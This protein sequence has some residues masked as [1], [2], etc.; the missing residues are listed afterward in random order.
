MCLLLP[1]LVKSLHAHKNDKALGV[2]FLKVVKRVKEAARQERPTISPAFCNS[3]VKDAVPRRSPRV[4]TQMKTE[5]TGWTPGLV[6]TNNNTNA[7]ATMNTNARGTMNTNARATMNTNARAKMNTN[8][9]S[10]V[11]TNV[12]AKVSLSEAK[13]HLRRKYAQEAMKK[14]KRTMVVLSDDAPAPTEKGRR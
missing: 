2:L 4:S 7:K 14:S 8:A 5:T 6:E 12:K 1:R 11:N 13:A 9:K 10:T 3:K